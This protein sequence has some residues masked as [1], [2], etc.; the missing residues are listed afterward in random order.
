[1]NHAMEVWFIIFVI[2]VLVSV[3]MQAAVLLGILFGMAKLY[4]KVKQIEAK[5]LSHGAVIA[6]MSA[7]ARK[8]LDILMRVGHNAEEV[9]ERVKTIADT[10]AE[11][12]NKQLVRADQMAEG[13]FALIERLSGYIEQGV[14]QPVREFQAISAGLRTA[15]SFLFHRSGGDGGF[16][17]EQRGSIFSHRKAG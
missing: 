17:E 2:A 13:V 11:V 6:E 14:V 10:A 12:S 1:M 7:D 15:A 4:V 3:V 9:S 16:R 8:A 5:L